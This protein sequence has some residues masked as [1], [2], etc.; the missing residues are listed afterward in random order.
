MRKFI[1]SQRW[2]K[3]AIAVSLILLL[4]LMV[5]AEA[6]ARTEAQS[7]PPA[8]GQ[9]EAQGETNAAVPSHREAAAELLVVMKV[10]SAITPSLNTIVDAQLKQNPSM[11]QYRDL[12]MAWAKKHLTWENISPRFVGL[13]TDAFTEQ[14]ILEMTAFYK[15]ST[16]QK[17]LTEM[18]E[19]WVKASTLGAALSREYMPE[20]QKMISDRKKELDLEREAH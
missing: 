12:I 9:K 4:A 18:P 3:K 2:S 1:A 10:E 5:N 8:S 6:K 13:L 19:I 14:E 15:T 20:L 16:G 17:T 11:G 7:P